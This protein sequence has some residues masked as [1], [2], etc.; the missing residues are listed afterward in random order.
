MP[1][2]EEEIRRKW[3]TTAD[4]IGPTVA[5]GIVELIWALAAELGVTVYV[6][7]TR[8]TLALQDRP[9]GPGVLEGTPFGAL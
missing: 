5:G 7:D 8:E 4:D 3:V 1:R 9:D 6:D 2:S